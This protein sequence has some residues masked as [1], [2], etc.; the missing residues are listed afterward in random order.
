MR[1]RLD[2]IE[3]NKLCRKDLTGKRFG[4]LIVIKEDGRNASNASTYMCQCDCGNIK[5]RVV[6]HYLNRGNTKSC[7][8]LVRKKIIERNLKGKEDLRG[9]KFGRLLVLEESG[10]TGEKYTY[11]CQCDCGTIRE[12]IAANSLKRGL[13]KSCGC[14]IHEKTSYKNVRERIKENIV[15]VNGCWEWQKRVARSGYAQIKYE[16][17]TTIA[18]RLSYKVFIGEIPENLLILHK[19]DNKKCV[20]PNHLFIG[21]YSDNMKDMMIKER[22]KKQSNLDKKDILEI[23]DLWPKLSIRELAELYKV[24]TTTIHKIVKNVTWKYI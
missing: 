20:N 23:R 16:G 13:T 6:S 22:N 10:K 9:K 11:R 24:S 5:E 15:E 18:H 4:N 17:I 1:K 12:K 21:T 3:R 7:G 14:L 2:N 19:C 8:C